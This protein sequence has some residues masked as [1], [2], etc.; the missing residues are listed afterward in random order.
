MHKKRMMLLVDYTSLAFKHFL[1]FSRNPTEFYQFVNK[2]QTPPGVGGDE[3]EDVMGGLMA[4]LTKLTWR[5]SGAKVHS[6]QLVTSNITV[7][8]KA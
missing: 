4:A 2:I 1:S 7:T 8:L 3:A 5:A 6:L